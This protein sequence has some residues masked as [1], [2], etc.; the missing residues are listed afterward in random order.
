[1]QNL[2]YL[3]SLIL[4]TCQDLTGLGKDTLLNE[5]C[6]PK[7]FISGKLQACPLD[8]IESPDECSF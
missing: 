6:V 5:N 7:S 4:F 3:P 2:S 1:M 8:L